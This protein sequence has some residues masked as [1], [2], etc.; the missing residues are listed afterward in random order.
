MT[1]VEI[2]F[3]KPRPAQFRSLGM[4]LYGAGLNMQKALAE[5]VQTNGKPDQIL[6]LEHDPVYTLGRSAVRTDIHQSDEFLAENGI[7]VRQTDRGGQVTY[8]GPGQVVV[9]PICNLREDRQSV[10]RFVRGLEQAMINSARDFGVDAGRLNGHPGAW[11]NTGRGLEKI[12]A[13]GVHLSRW[14]STHG[15]AFNLDPCMNHFGWITPCGISDKGVCSLRSILGNGCPSREEVEKS[16]AKHLSEILALD[17]APAASPSESISAIVWRRG[18]GGPEVLMMLRCPSDG[19]WW[20]SSTGMVEDGEMPEAAAIRETQEECGL[21]GKIQPLDF[22]H[23]FWMDPRLE[24][25]S[26]DEPQFCT[27]NCFH[28]EVA[29]DAFVSLNPMKH[30]EYRWCALEAAIRLTAWEGSK[31]ALKKLMRYL[32]G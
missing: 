27:E 25:I 15:I 9:Y 28:I 2:G 7:E 21:I 22:K 12:G 19:V 8:H 26:S 5:H 11:V 32:T 18:L 23:T 1:K 10:G 6:I 13:L 20:S 24:K 30:S 16:L 17:P 29:P 3:A 14:V 4:V 31:T